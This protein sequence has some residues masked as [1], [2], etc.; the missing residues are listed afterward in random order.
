M[1]SQFA[2]EYIHYDSVGNLDMCRKAIQKSKEQLKQV[3]NSKQIQGYQLS[4]I[5][6]ELD[7]EEKS[8]GDNFLGVT[9]GKYPFVYSFVQ[10]LENSTI[11]FDSI[12]EDLYYIRVNSSI[13]SNCQYVSMY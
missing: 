10:P 3:Y 2:H 13:L 6:N 8:I 4:L 12:M 9:H 11:N 7:V 1:I 5:Q